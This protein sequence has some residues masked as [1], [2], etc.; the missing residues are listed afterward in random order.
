[1]NVLITG[2]SSG[3][4]YGFAKH[5]LEFGHTVYGISRTG[6]SDLFTYVNYNHLYL[7][8]TNHNNIRKEFHAIITNVNYIDYVVLNAG[9]LGEISDLIN[10]SL[11]QIENI[12]NINVWSNKVLIDELVK[13]KIPINHIIAISS[14]ASVSG[15]RG[16]NGYAISKASLNMLIK[17]YAAELPNI[18]FTSLAPGLVDTKMQDYICNLTKNDQFPIVER[19]KSARHTD[20]MPDAI[21][22]GSILFKTLPHLK[23][24]NSGSFV[25]L[26]DL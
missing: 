23:S 17:L 2:T 12:M 20:K 3:I 6:N 9:I 14:G 25:D 21:H 5:C 10:T 7:D 11:D 19:L 4:G 26:R 1:M 16:W 24:Y 15:S 18:H 13:T 22:F 8:L